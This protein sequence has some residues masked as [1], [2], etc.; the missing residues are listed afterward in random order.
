[1]EH[2]FQNQLS[3]VEEVVIRGVGYSRKISDKIENIKMSKNTILLMQLH[4]LLDIIY[5]SC[6]RAL[7]PQLNKERRVKIL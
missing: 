1:M 2:L 3:T 6:I 5:S 4:V 7:F